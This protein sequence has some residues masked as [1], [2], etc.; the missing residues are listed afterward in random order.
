MATVLSTLYPPLVS[1]FMPAFLTSEDATVQF[2]ISAYNATNTINRLHVSL[3]YQYTNKK[4]I[5]NKELPTND[6][7]GA[8]SIKIINMVQEIIQL[9]LIIFEL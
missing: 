4:A 7:S 5:K 1:D 3:V 6:S 8:N 2:S 9:L